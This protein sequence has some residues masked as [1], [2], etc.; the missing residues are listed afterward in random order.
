MFH[1]KRFLLL[2]IFF[3]LLL[4]GQNY[5]TSNSKAIKLFEKGQSAF[6]KGN[7]QDALRCFEQSLEEDPSF[8]EANIMLAE[9]YLDAK[10]PAKAKYHYYAVV[11]TDPSFFTQAWLQIGNLELNDDNNEEAKYAYQQFLVLDKKAKDRHAAAQKGIETAEFRIQARSNPVAF[12]PENMGITVNSKNDEYLPALT[13]DGKTLIFTRRFPR[14]ANT[15]PGINEEEDFYISTLESNGWSQAKRMSEP[16]NSNDNE[17]A[18]CISQDGRIM[19]FTACGRQ[20]GAGR[21]DLYMCTRK[22]EKW[23]KPRNLGSP[24]NTGAWESQPSFSI[25]GRTLYFVSDR[26]GGY[27]GLDIWKTVYGDR[28]WSEPENLGP[29]INTSGDEMSPFIHYD[30]HTLYFSSNGHIGMGGMD[31]FVSRL[32]DDGSWSKPDNLGYPINT[33]DDETN[34]IVSADGQTALYSSNREGGYGKQDLYSFVL[35]EELRPTITI[36]MTGIVTDMQTDAK[37]SAQIQVIDLATG[38]LVAATT[39]DSQTGRYQISLPA[40]NDYA[41]HATAKGYLFYSQNYELDHGVERDW[42]WKPDEVN[43]AMSRMESGQRL[44]LRNVF[45]ETNRSEVKEESQVEL[46][47]LAEILRNN[48]A[49]RIELGGHTDNVGRPEDNRRLS[50]ARAKAVYDYLVSHGIS[51][52]RMTFKGY[53]E[54]QPVAPNDTEENRQQ[55]RRTELKIL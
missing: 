8:M 47:K 3:P 38:R 44:T 21:C 18:Q 12:H 42:T 36:C 6:Y 46:N 10:Q 32:Q 37:L 45:F 31:L 11:K 29:S 2:I 41:I 13:V 26:K 27:G 53:G 54:S 35:P 49:M 33:K 40:G 43:I 15:V 16:V 55:N 1:M 50:E 34:L 20:D 30:D 39:S 28:G 7:V 52:D 24:V 17:G 51:S 4:W 22:G 23:S 9:W 5:S 14:N 48:P 25:D 19:F